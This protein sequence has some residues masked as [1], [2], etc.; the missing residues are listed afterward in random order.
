MTTVLDD[1]RAMLKDAA[2][3]FCKNRSPITAFREL[4]DASDES[5]FSRE[6]WKEM[7][8]MG[9][10]GALF[11]EDL[12]GFDFGMRGM[13]LI[14][15]E[16]G[17]TLVASPLI[18]T[19]ILSGSLVQLAGNDAQREDV[20]SA[21]IAGDRLLSVAIDERHAHNPS[22]IT[23]KAEKSG[24]GY[25]ITGEKRFVID[26]HVAD[27]LIIATR[28]SGNPGDEDGI[29]LFLVDANA[30][31]ITRTR[32]HM[33]DSRNSALIKLDNVQV[34]ESAILG[35]VGNGFAP[36]N[37]ALDRARVAIAAEMLGATMQI[38]GT[39]IE[40]LKTRVQ[41]EVQIGTFQALQHRAAEMFGEIEMARSVVEAAC[42]AIDENADNTSLLASLAKAKL[43]DTFHLVSN[44]TIQMHGGIGMTDECDVGF[45][46]KRS[47][48][49]TE[50]FGNSRFHRNRYAALKGY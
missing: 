38:F 33:V 32:T 50:T 48:V 23:T 22:N 44:E 24:S 46:L 9:W 16:T 28:T 34:D 31:G 19:V 8:D 18:S 37:Q 1:E 5:G 6:L 3:E 15:E 49:A 47:R 35:E 11:P 4:R 40:Y 13:G 42:K 21:I 43:N 27:Q 45:Y 30:A 2:A 36:L 14:L 39:T 41:F 25:T 12:G 29:T 26:G 20:L 10:A 7:A 17:R